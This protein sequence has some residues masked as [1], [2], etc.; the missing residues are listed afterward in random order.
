MQI[1]DSWVENRELMIEIVISESKHDWTFEDGILTV[2]W[3]DWRIMMLREL[4]Q[5]SR[6]G[7]I[8]RIGSWRRNKGIDIK[9]G[10][11]TGLWGKQKDR[12]RQEQLSQRLIIGSWKGLEIRTEQV[13]SS[14]GGYW[15]WI[16]ND[17]RRRWQKVF[18]LMELSGKDLFD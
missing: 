15:L 16:C 4:N 7:G 11:S 12:T 18:V 9:T 2:V 3:I 17:D 13:L 8:C 14:S 10:Y 5:S 1:V 6:F